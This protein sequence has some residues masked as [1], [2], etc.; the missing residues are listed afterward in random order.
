[1]A[2]KAEFSGKTKPPS[3]S[4]LAQ[5][6]K[7]PKKAYSQGAMFYDESGKLQVINRTFCFHCKHS[8][9]TDTTK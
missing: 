2:I 5:C 9:Y 3:W 7:C 6:K 8:E 1:M 4:G